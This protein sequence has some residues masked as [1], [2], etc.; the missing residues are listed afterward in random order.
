MPG[1]TDNQGRGVEP[2]FH[3]PLSEASKVPSGAD[4]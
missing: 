2:P 3:G 1:G 4:I